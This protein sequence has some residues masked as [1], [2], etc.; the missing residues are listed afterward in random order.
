M[1]LSSY[2]NDGHIMVQRAGFEP[3]VD[4][5]HSIMSG[6]PPTNRASVASILGGSYWIL[7]SASSVE[8]F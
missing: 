1:A 2:A 7:T 3:A 4:F 8:V 5:R 6:G